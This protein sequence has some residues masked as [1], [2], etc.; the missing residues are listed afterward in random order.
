MWSKPKLVRCF[1]AAV[2]CGLGVFSVMR[3]IPAFSKKG[4]YRAI[5]AMV[6][7]HGVP[8]CASVSL[9]SLAPKPML[10]YFGW[11]ITRLMVLISFCSCC[12]LPFQ[13]LFLPKHIG[14]GWL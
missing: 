13:T 6:S 7:T 2:M 11:I 8:A 12:M 9:T 14:G 3:C 1:K 5:T 4:L 10:L